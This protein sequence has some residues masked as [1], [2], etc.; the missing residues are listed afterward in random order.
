VGVA[1]RRST[2]ALVARALGVVVA[3]SAVVEPALGSGP[4]A[5]VVGSGWFDAAVAVGP[6]G[7]VGVG[8][9]VPLAGV[10]GL[11]LGDAVADGAGAG[12]SRTGDGAGRGRVLALAL[13]PAGPAGEMR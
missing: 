1:V 10:V 9:G 6:V 12:P 7:A 4:P 8:V 2:E 3:R 13:A 5:D 11:A